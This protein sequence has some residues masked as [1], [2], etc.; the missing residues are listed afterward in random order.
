[1]TAVQAVQWPPVIE[2]RDQAR[3]VR[4]RAIPA[5]LAF[6][7]SEL[8]LPS[9]KIIQPELY[10]SQAAP[11]SSAE[12]MDLRTLGSGGIFKPNSDQLVA[13]VEGWLKQMSE[14]GC[15]TAY[16]RG[17]RRPTP[18]SELMIQ[19]LFF[20]EWRPPVEQRFIGGSDFS[21]YDLNP[22]PLY[23]SSWERFHLFCRTAW[24]KFGIEVMYDIVPHAIG[25]GSPIARQHPEEILDYRGPTNDFG[26]VLDYLHKLEREEKF[27][28]LG[29][30]ECTNQEGERER[31]SVRVYGDLPEFGR[32]D[33]KPYQKADPKYQVI[34]CS[35]EI[36]KPDAAQTDGA[37]HQVWTA[38]LQ[39]DLERDKFFP[40]AWILDSRRDDPA[41]PY[42]K[43]LASQEDHAN[44]EVGWFCDQLAWDIWNPNA[45][46]RLARSMADAMPSSRRARVDMADK[47]VRLG[48]NGRKWFREL[49]ARVKELSGLEP[50]FWTEAYFEHG[51]LAAQGTQAYANFFYNWIVKEHFNVHE[52]MDRLFW[53]ADFYRRANLVGYIGNHDDEVK[54][55]LNCMIGAAAAMMV[56]MPFR[57]IL[58]P[59]GL[60]LG[61]TER[62]GADRHMPLDVYNRRVASHREAD[63]D[64]AAF[65]QQVAKLSSLAVF[66]SPKSD[67]H[68]AALDW[69]SQYNG[70]KFFHP[71][72]DKIFHL[73]RTL[74]TGD[75]RIE[76]VLGVVSCC[77]YNPLMKIGINLCESFGMP[78]SDLAQHTL[79]NLVDGRVSPAEKMFTFEPHPS[80]AGFDA[81]L[82]GLVPNSEL[83]RLRS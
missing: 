74:D 51:D 52:V 59:Q 32:E 34:R 30:K 29:C 50:A 58:W 41:R 28:D 14:Y 4:V 22:D 3:V 57:S 19:G 48:Q 46:D 33:G 18:E 55:P 37:L 79:V 12:T 83:F 16:V 17:L 38:Y 45:M 42:C 47:N 78:Q 71:N 31:H 21:V 1:M 54:L 70:Y 56:L 2:D 10:F 5:R 64:F 77:G 81:G 39:R 68:F 69:S 25:L 11:G 36:S 15:D 6:D 76:R 53:H 26:G 43:K 27:W 72:P 40:Y 82:W 7:P 49:G 8:A 35:C 61:W 13:P 44:K 66:R 9:R 62:H 20:F 23:F 60:P 67:F 75:G 63:Q 65:M 24:E 73:V 80:H